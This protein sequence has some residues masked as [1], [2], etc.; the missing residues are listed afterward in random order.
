MDG[1]E[2]WLEMTEIARLSSQEIIERMRTLTGWRI[3]DDRLIKD[4]RFENFMAAIA[5]VNQVAAVAEAEGHHP[6]LFVG[7]G[8]VSLS[9]TTHS[10]GG[11]TAKDFDLAALIERL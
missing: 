4:F 3:Q 10:A 2:R 9:L 1:I 8:R 5:F 7:W 6:D 11:L